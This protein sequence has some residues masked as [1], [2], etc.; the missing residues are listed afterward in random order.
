MFATD[1]LEPERNVGNDAAIIW[2]EIMFFQI[3]V[4]SPL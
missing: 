3:K 2:Q 4:T 1:E